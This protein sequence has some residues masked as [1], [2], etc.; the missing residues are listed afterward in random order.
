MGLP[1]QIRND[2]QANQK[3]EAVDI[4]RRNLNKSPTIKETPD[5]PVDFMDASEYMGMSPDKLT[6]KMILLEYIRKVGTL[7]SCEFRG[8][9]YS[10]VETKHG[11]KEIYVEDTRERLCN[12]VEYLFTILCPHFDKDMKKKAKVF[13]KLK[14]KLEYKFIKDSTPEEEV[15]LGDAFYDLT[16]DKV[17]LETYKQKKLKLYI[18]LFRQLNRFLYRYRYMDSVPYEDKI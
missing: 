4:M 3:K 14:K 13:E 2:N 16:K 7:F 1:E 9:F 8:G 6:F 18:L 5:I 15:I 11:Q 10:M 12:A 17:L